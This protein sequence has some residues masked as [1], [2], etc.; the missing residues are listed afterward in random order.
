MIF[1]NL[2]T[3]LWHFSLPNQETVIETAPEAEEDCKKRKEKK[4]E[5]R[6]KS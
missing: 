6:K 5:L 1:N 2:F 4:S 3:L